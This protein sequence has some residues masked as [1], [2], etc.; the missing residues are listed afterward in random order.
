MAQPASFDWLAKINR[1]WTARLAL[2][3]LPENKGPKVEVFRG[4]V[5]V[6]P[7][8]VFDHQEIELELAH[9]MKRAARQTGLWLYHEVNLVSGD[10]LFIPDIVVLRS[11]GAGKVSVDISEA[12][13]LGEIVSKGSR[14]KDV[15]DRPREYAAAGV[16]WFL[17]IDF[18][19]RVPA[20][21]LFALEDGEYR[22]TV[23]A[24][25]GSV[26]AMKEPFEFEID[27]AD[28][29]ED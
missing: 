2:D 13:L 15:I 16:P 27:P 5:I 23:A 19:N 10:D 28:L 17:R 22:P 7:H 12:V 24:A 25:A 8:A 3:L 14:R 6:T 26:F 9:R 11:S 1:S 29:V 20:L 4:S 18:R 21:A